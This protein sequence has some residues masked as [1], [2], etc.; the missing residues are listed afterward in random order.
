MTDFEKD[1]QR[2]LRRREPPQDLAPG[3][4]ARIGAQPTR[5]WKFWGFY[6]RQ[7][8]AA[9]AAL[10]VLG[11]G[12]DQYREYRKGQEAKRQLILALQ[13]TNQKLSVVQAKVDKLNRRSIGHDR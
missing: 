10:L 9:V 5:Q 7:A 6:W 13:I 1:L 2:T 8:V 4:M 12:L 3:I 11:V